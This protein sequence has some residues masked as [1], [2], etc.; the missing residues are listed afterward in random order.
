MHSLAWRTLTRASATEPDL[1]CCMKLS[2]ALLCKLCTSCTRCFVASAAFF[3]G[4]YAALRRSSSS[5]CRHDSS[6]TTAAAGAAA[7]AAGGAHAATG[8]LSGRPG[9][10]APTTG[11]GACVAATGSDFDCPGMVTTLARRS[12][13]KGAGP[14]VR[15]VLVGGAAGP[16]P[17]CSPS[18]DADAGMYPAPGGGPPPLNGKKD[19][20]II[21]CGGPPNANG[22]DDGAITGCGGCW[23]IL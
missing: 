9:G 10:G 6:P 11:A 20:A 15:C 7:A 13:E 4:L 12:L 2:L 17:C 22:T 1:F 19:G 3:A 23:V 18:V 21:G 5:T 8:P 16:N 14:P